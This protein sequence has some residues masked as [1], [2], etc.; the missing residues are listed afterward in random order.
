MGKAKKVLLFELEEQMHPARVEDVIY[1]ALKYYYENNN[2]ETWKEM[3]A[4]SLVKAKEARA[5]RAEEWKQ[6][7]E[8][9]GFKEGDIAPYRN[10]RGKIRLAKITKFKVI[11]GGKVWFHGINTT[12]KAKVWY[13]THISLKLKKE[14]EVNNGKD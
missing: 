5:A 12:T 14:S 8:G 1:D 13:S 4:Y 7:I 10:T 2:N 9:C 11:E 3:I 6:S